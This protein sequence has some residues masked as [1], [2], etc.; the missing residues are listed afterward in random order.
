MNVDIGSQATIVV[1]GSRA[2]PR[3]LRGRGVARSSGACTGARR[4]R[5]PCAEGTHPPPLRPAGRARRSRIGDLRDPRIAVVVLGR[6]RVPLRDGGLGRR[7]RLGEVIQ[8]TLG[9]GAVVTT[10]DLSFNSTS[11]APPTP[12]VA[13]SSPGHARSKSVHRSVSPRGPSR[14]AAV[15]SWRM[16]RRA[17]SSTTSRC[18][19]SMVRSQRCPR[20][21]TTRRTRTSAPHRPPVPRGGRGVRSRP[22]WQP[23]GVAS[24][25]RH[26]APSCSVHS[27]PRP[28][29]AP[30]RCP[31]ARRH[32]S[33]GPQAL[34][35]A[36][37]RHCCWTSS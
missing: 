14:T 33:A 12:R 15:V 20:P 8:V 37:S 6:G 16:R 27:T 25:R 36:A 18:L 24:F 30:R 35:T 7:R 17:A 3:R 32:G 28:A 34:S 10:S 13:R 29:A 19:R 1:D 2:G 22:S 5:W 23:S 26:R 9:P 11:C 31:F 4:H 21:P